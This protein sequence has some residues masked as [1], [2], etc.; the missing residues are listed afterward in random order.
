MCVVDIYHTPYLFSFLSAKAKE[1][2]HETPRLA[3]AKSAPTAIPL[4]EF[5]PQVS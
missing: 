3:S 4:R 2:I 5:P 1:F